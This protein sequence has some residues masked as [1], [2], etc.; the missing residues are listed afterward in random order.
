MC[1]V[2]HVKYDLEKFYTHDVIYKFKHA[3]HYMYLITNLNEMDCLE[4]HSYHSVNT[5]HDITCKFS[6]KKTTF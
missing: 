2:V 3:I 1:D 4:F 6:N 5:S